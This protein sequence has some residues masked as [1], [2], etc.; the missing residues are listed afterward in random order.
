MDSNNKLTMKNQ[1]I[2]PQETTYY[3][4]YNGNYEIMAYGL[5]EP[6]NQMETGQP[7]MEIYLD[8]T[9]WEN[10]L[11]KNGIELIENEFEDYD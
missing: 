11:F 7:I 10:V 1:I 4:C 3:I 9:E 8:L 5:V 6:E 2:Y